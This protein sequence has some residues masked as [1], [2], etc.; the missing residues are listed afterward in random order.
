MVARLPATRLLLVLSGDRVPRST[1]QVAAAAGEDPATLPAKAA[2]A[3]GR[4]STAWLE[5][6]AQAAAAG[7][8]IDVL[9]IEQGRAAA[10][11]DGSSTGSVAAAVPPGLKVVWATD[12]A[13]AWPAVREVLADGAVL[14]RPDGHVAWR[15]YSAPPDAAAGAKALADAVGAIGLMVV[16]Q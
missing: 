8:P 2:P 16:R 14:V 3:A 13:G 7:A 9:V 11:A 5:A 6:A 12:A 4:G 1:A 15:R 10:I